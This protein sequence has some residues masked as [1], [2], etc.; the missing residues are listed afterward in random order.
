MYK[1]ENLNIVTME[2]GLGG[3]KM[4]YKPRNLL[5][6]LNQGFKGIMIKIFRIKRKKDT[7]D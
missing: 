6:M 3:K 2:K 4:H 1:L 7:C 5:T